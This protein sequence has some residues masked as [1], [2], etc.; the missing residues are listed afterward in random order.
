MYIIDLQ[1]FNYGKDGYI[2]KEITIFN[3]M[4]ESYTHKMIKMSHKF[5]L[6][7]HSTQ[8]LLNWLTNNIH[9]LNWNS[10]N[11]DFLLT[12]ELVDFI[13]REVKDD[14]VLVKGADKKKWLLKFLKNQIID[15]FEEGCPNLNKLKSIFKSYHCNQHY[16]NSLNCSLENVYFIYFWYVY[17][18]CKNKSLS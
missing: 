8:N 7:N 10:Y 14:V 4:T 6:F 13:K 16:H 15:L 17:V 3:M 5:E 18:H 9:G 12:E 2:W 1:G 11:E